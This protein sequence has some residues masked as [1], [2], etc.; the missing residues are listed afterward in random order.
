MCDLLI[1]GCL[2]L[3]KISFGVGFFEFVGLV[4]DGLYVWPAE[5]G[6][7]FSEVD[8]L[9]GKSQRGKVFHQSLIALVE[10]VNGGLVELL[11]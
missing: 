11:F 10:L 2:N 6:G 8:F 3:L 9:V 5:E 4:H 7:C 1:L